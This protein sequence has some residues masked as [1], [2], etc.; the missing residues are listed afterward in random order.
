MAIQLLNYAD[1]EDTNQHLLSE[2]CVFTKDN[3][4]K[5]ER[6]GKERVVSHIGPLP[7]LGLKP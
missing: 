5:I 2:F 7:R 4:F 6:S 1:E 3:N